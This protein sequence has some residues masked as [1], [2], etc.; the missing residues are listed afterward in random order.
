MPPAQVADIRFATM[1]PNSAI[2]EKP[3]IAA[4]M[5][6]NAPTSFV[7]TTSSIIYSI[8]SGKNSSAAL[9]IALN[10]SSAATLPE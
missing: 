10:T 5:S 1:L 2:K 9:P 3:S 7:G 8:M 4:P 6:I